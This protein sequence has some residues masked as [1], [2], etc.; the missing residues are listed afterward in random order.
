MSTELMNTIAGPAGLLG[1]LS[2]LISIFSFKMAQGL[3]TVIDNAEHRK[4]KIETK[5]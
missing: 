5:G 4:W 1:A 3:Q 2:L